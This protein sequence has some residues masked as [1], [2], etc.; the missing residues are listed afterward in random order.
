MCLTSFTPHLFTC[1][2]FEP[3]YC[4]IHTP[5]HT[6]CAVTSFSILL[7]PHSSLSLAGNLAQA[8]DTHVR[9]KANDHHTPASIHTR[10]SSQ[11][12]AHLFPAADRR[13]PAP[14]APCQPTPTSAPTSPW[15]SSPRLHSPQV[16]M[17]SCAL[18]R[19]LGFQCSPCG[20]FTNPLSEKFSSYQFLWLVFQGQ[21]PW[22]RLTKKPAIPSDLLDTTAFHSTQTSTHEPNPTYT[23]HLPSSPSTHEP[24][25]AYTPHLLSFTRPHSQPLATLPSLPCCTSARTCA[26]APAASPTPARYDDDS[27]RPPVVRVGEYACVDVSFVHAYVRATF[28]HMRTTWGPPPAAYAS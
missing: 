13:G 22:P 1:R 17:P 18:S 21:C 14:P 4:V 16:C 26:P 23:L 19:F 7:L 15:Q 6:Q 3:A 27:M 12:H 28:L 25:L 2:L 5:H 11:T 9:R 8:T 20:S 24:N 10:A